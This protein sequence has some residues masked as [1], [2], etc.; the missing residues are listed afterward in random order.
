MKYRQPF[1]LIQ[2]NKVWYYRVFDE[3][4]KRK[5]YSTGQISKA[6]AMA[7]VM[8]K[9]KQGTL[10]PDKPKLNLITFA[11]YAKNWWDWD[12]CLYLRHERARGMEYSRRYCDNQAKNMTNHLVPAFGRMK[13]HQITVAKVEDWLFSL[14]EVQNLAPKTANNQLSIMSVMMGEAC[15]RGLIKINPCEAVRPLKPK[16]KDRGILTCQEVQKL[17]SSLD[18][19]D[20]DL[21][22]FAGN[23]VAACT[24]MRSREVAGP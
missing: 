2:R 9:F 1:T 20:N 6:K 7:Y 17:F 11:T 14:V 5:T 24:G 22:G 10:I 13:L 12:K 18:I 3:E 8:S 16:C 23:V 4:G 21:Y 15:R 19:W